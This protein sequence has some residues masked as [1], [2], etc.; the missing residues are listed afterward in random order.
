M[1]DGAS[2]QAWYN[3]TEQRKAIHIDETTDWRCDV[4][5]SMMVE[6]MF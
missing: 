4:G 3:M 6:G 5:D 2:E 1:L